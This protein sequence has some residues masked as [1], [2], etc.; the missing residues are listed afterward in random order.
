M[1]LDISRSIQE[2]ERPHL[3]N[4]YLRSPFRTRYFV[5]PSLLCLLDLF[6]IAIISVNQW[7]RLPGRSIYPLGLAAFSLIMVWVMSLRTQKAVSRYLKTAQVEELEPGS[8]LEKGLYVA[9][10]VTYYGSLWTLG[11]VA[12]CLAA[13]G[14]FFIR[15]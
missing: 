12:F 9:G 3:S 1:A 2:A 7:E 4:Y 8:S 14:E 10:Y 13:F 15:G 11:A 5:L 6:L